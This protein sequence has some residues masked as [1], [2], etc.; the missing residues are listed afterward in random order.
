V[1]NEKKITWCENWLK[2][3]FS[4]YKGVE[5]NLLF[6]MAKKAG[7]YTSGEYES[8]LSKAL[9]NLN[10]TVEIIFNNDGEF[11]YRA[12]HISAE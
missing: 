8:E 1:L 7:L 5:R 4:K 2:E 10:A 9:L 12:I 6:E 11:L 3:L